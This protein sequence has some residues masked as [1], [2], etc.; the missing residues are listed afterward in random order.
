MLVELVTLYPHRLRTLRISAP[1][2]LLLGHMRAF[3]GLTAPQMTHLSITNTRPSA[4]MLAAHSNER[5]TRIFTGEGTK[6]LHFKCVKIG[7]LFQPPLGSLTSLTLGLHAPV[8][9]GAIYDTFSEAAPKL[10][11]LAISLSFIDDETS[12]LQPINMLALDAITITARMGGAF[13]ALGM[14]RAPCLHNLELLLRQHMPMSRH[15]QL[16]IYG[17][18]VDRFPNL[19]TLRLSGILGDV[20]L[21][22]FPTIT[23]LVIGDALTT[24]TTLQDMFDPRQHAFS[25]IAPGLMYI[26]APLRFK[27]AVQ[28]FC[29]AR[30][31]FGLG[32]PTHQEMEGRSSQQV[33]TSSHFCSSSNLSRTGFVCLGRSQKDTT[34][35]L[36][37][38][39]RTA[40]PP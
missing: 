10:V 25:T 16:P 38:T 30:L 23:E 18:T 12:M 8:S 15:L 6:L 13:V 7:P 34:L 26:M 14:I 9:Y 27:Q 2:S 19:H 24:L 5:S 1:W 4:N 29:A 35:S 32:A 39:R 31:T 28:D 21:A 20:I 22:P 33:M 37:Q 3:H 40:W 11:Q 17:S 36:R